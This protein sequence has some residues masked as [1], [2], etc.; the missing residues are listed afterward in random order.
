M[1]LNIA[2]GRHPGYNVLLNQNYV[3][4]IEPQLTRE[5]DPRQYP[6]KV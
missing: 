3:W 4:R 1:E 6:Y 2:Y 5:V